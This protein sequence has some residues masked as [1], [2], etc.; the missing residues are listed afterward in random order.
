MPPPLN[1][2]GRV[3]GKLTVLGPGPKVQFGRLQRGWSCR[4]EC[5]KE[6]VVAQD[7]LPHRAAIA[8]IRGRAVVACQDCS[9][10]ICK[11]CG[12]SIPRS[13]MPAVTCLG[14]CADEYR[15]AKGRASFR[16]RMERDPDL[17]ARMTARR[18]ARCETDPDYAAHFA[19]HERR[20]Q[21]RRSERLRTDPEYAAKAR[22]RARHHYAANADRILA[23]RRAALDRMTPEEREAWAERAR[24]FCRDWRRKWHAELTTDP[25]A[26]ARYRQIQ[27]EYQRQRRIAQQGPVPERTCVVCG[28]TFATRKYRVLCDNRDCMAQ[29]RRD[30]AYRSRARAAATQFRELERKLTR[31]L[32]ERHDRDRAKPV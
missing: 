7:R 17:I 16:R 2:T 32:H 18:K 4:C 25:A 9:G 20:R 15:K 13:R 23:E 31:R 21:Q 8:A 11:V 5:G 26:H 22:A 29:Y 6:L 30:T 28:G 3:F 14:H 10:G 24:R 12:A 27:N 1:L 19:E